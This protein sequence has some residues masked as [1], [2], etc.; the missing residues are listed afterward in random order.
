VHHAHQRL[1]VHRDLKP[2]NILVSE[3]QPETSAPG[4]VK[5]LDFG[6]AKLLDE[7][8]PSGSNRTQTGLFLMTP[9]Y[10]APEQVRGGEIT[11]ATD[12]YALGL[13][14]YEMLVGEPP[15]QIAGQTPQQI[16]QT[17]CDWSPAV[18]SSRVTGDVDGLN[19]P[20]S[21]AVLRS[22]LRGDLDAIVLKALEKEPERR[23]SSAL[24]CAQDIERYRK[25]LPVEAKPA[26]RL[27]L[28]ARFVSRHRLAVGVVVLVLGFAIGAAIRER[29]NA[30]RIVEERDRADQLAS[31]L[32]D[33][34]GDADPA[35]TRGRE[36]TAR[37]LLARGA[38]RVETDL[39]GKPLEQ[40][41]LWSTIGLIYRN[42]GLYEDAEILQR[43]AVTIGAEAMGDEHPDVLQARA[44]LGDVLHGLGDYD[45]AEVQMRKAFEGRTLSLGAN[46]Q[47]TLDSATGLGI[48]LEY[49]GEL[50]EAER[51]LDI[52]VQGLLRELG[53][54]NE[55]TLRAQNA[56]ASV[57]YSAGEWARAEKLYRQVL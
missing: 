6:I 24:A 53:P 48:I 32:V 43:R 14:L 19:A 36:V 37:E 7:S 10:A 52:A 13:L 51:V 23:Y 38:S 3:P 35:V 39:A 56:K 26:G 12:V 20:E 44:R 50:D 28:A 1:V 5:L 47:L 18:P 41:R 11:T 15:Y 33:V 57:L 31:F 27:Y 16:L 21:I 45:A 30:E 29:L 2:S 46:H 17:I 8:N 49:K 9:Q 34:F 40:M 25:G 22:K 42:L 4:F 54:G 55:L